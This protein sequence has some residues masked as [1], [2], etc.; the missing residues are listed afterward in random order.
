MRTFIFLFASLSIMLPIF[1]EEVSNITGAE[2]D[3][4]LYNNTTT[5]QSLVRG[6]SC[7]GVGL[8]INEPS[9][10]DPFVDIQV[11]Q[12]LTPAL[13]TN[14]VRIYELSGRTTNWVFPTNVPIAFFAFTK[15]QTYR[16]HAVFFHPEDYTPEYCFSITNDMEMAKFM[17][18]NVDRAW[19][20]VTR[21]NGL[22][23]AFATNL[24]NCVRANPNPTNYYELLRD[25]ERTVSKEDSWRVK[26]DAHR[27]LSWLFNEEPESDLAEKLNDPLLSITKKNTLGNTLMD[28]FGWTY[29]YT[30]NV[31]V[32][33]P[34]Q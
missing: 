31:E 20:R 30:N 23:Y 25:A 6:A 13:S 14:V 29:S 32:W 11:Q 21:D 28:R 12:W 3:D 4:K 10:A 5:I 34:P 8:F 19:F 16:D 18:P 22:V 9:P 15:R 27:G 7:V 2:L 33:T 1:A 26:F 17:F 24:W